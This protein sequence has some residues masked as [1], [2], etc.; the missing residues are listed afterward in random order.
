MKLK[1]KKNSQYMKRSIFSVL[2]ALLFSSI[3]SQIADNYAF[4]SEFIYGK[5]FKH[6]KHL[7][8]IVKAAP[9]GAELAI[10][11]KTRGDKDWH[12]YYHFPTIGLG[13]NYLDLGNPSI[14]GQSIALYPYLN[15]PIWKNKC[16]DLNFKSGVGMSYVTKTFKSATVYDENGNIL[17]DESNAAIGS[18]LNVFIA[19]GLNLE[20]PI[21]SGFS[22]VGDYA[23]NHISNGSVIV[24]NSGLNMLNGYV[25]LKYFPYFKNYKQ[26]EKKEMADISKNITFQIVASG[27]IRQR[28]YTDNKSLPIASLTISAY[29]PTTNFYR[30]GTG[31]DVFYDGIFTNNLSNLYNRT[32]LT[33]NEFKNKLR[34]GFSLHNELIF[35]RLT[36][37]IHTGIY[38]Y[39]PIKNA[40]PYTD[41]KNEILHKGL[42]Y[43]YNIEKEDGWFYTRFV[44]KY[45]ISNNVFLSIGLKTHL[46]K[47]EFIEWGLGYKL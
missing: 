23:W 35:G 12:Q 44:G 6:T 43:P 46:Q 32:Y 14:L 1:I 7:A 4:K 40:E 11:W 13:I 41:A 24:P 29:K 19:A 15:I 39:N 33:S 17:F 27:G 31:I 30:V 28:H 20:I 16:I 9:R 42:I 34:I 18:H 45:T 38:L 26:F 25:G 8:N 2:F 36:A 5:I 22:L 21:S 37:G 10:E 47:A 3:F